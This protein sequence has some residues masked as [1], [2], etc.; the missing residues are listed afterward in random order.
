MRLIRTWGTNV[1]VA[2]VTV[3]V[4]VATLTPTGDRSVNVGAACLGCGTFGLSD[5]VLNVMLFAPLG[6]LLGRAGLPIIFALGFGVLLSG[7]IETLQMYIPGRSAT[8]R[9]V[10]TN[11]IG[12]GLGGA[13]GL[14]LPVLLQ[15]GRRATVFLAITG[16][17]L[18]LAAGLTG[19]FSRFAP[20]T[21][22]DYFGQ[23]VSDRSNLEQWQGTVTRA[24]VDGLDVPNGRNRAITSEL[25][26]A[27]A[28]T[29]RERIIGTAGPPTVRT[30]G[31][32]GLM[33]EARDE[34]LLVGPHG[35]DLVVRVR[36]N[37][38]MWRLHEPEF[39][40]RNALAAVPANAPLEI[41]LEVTR[42]GG[43]VTVNGTAHCVGRPRLGSTWTLG[44]GY[45][46]KTTRVDG[47]LRAITLLVLVLPFALLIRSAARGGRI[48]A[49]TMLMIGLPLVGYAAGLALPD[50]WERASLVLALFGG[51]WI[52]QRLRRDLT[53]VS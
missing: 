9:D 39:V 32:F 15:P 2:V 40:F 51:W 3:A 13:V 11:A 50:V 46:P 1:A 23:W 26:R 48:A 47:A 36:R 10:L 53:S 19:Y 33:T 34:A 17:A 45:Y 37:A 44:L 7:G 16:S 28:D 31:I 30:G 42:L 24:T 8:L 29:V 43:C 25:Q 6:L 21:S 27:L 49:L 52:N 35:H 18:L 4:L 38:A 12:C 14:Y 20:P 5:L 22:G 41:S